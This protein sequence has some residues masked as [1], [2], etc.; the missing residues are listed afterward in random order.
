MYEELQQKI[1]S[2]AITS[3]EIQIAAKAIHPNASQRIKID[4]FIRLWS[5][6]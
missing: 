3:R 1:E 6:S 2:K 4:E 5:A